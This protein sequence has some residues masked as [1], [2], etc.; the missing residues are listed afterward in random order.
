VKADGAKLSKSSGDTGVRELRAAGLSPAEV[1]GRAASSV[2]LI[3]T[4][5]P[6]DQ[7]EVETL[8]R[9]NSL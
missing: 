9:R 5:R 8:F 2:G 6:L 4:Y 3:R 1:I 7:L